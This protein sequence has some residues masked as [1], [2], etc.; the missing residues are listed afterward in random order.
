MK[1]KIVI[2]L[3]DLDNFEKTI[4]QISMLFEKILYYYAEKNPGYFE[5][6]VYGFMMYFYM[7][8]QGM[9]KAGGE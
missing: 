9:K 2:V 3:D 4:N 8:Y 6:F 1:E 5:Q 7:I